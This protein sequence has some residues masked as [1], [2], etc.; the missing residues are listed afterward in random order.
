LFKQQS[1]TQSDED[2]FISR[3]YIGDYYDYRY[4]APEDLAGPHLIWIKTSLENI[5]GKI[6]AYGKKCEFKPGERLYLKRTLFTPGIGKGYWVFYIENDSGISYE[7]TEFQNDH[8]TST[9]KIFQS[10]FQQ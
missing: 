5:F 6:S 8:K 3:R 9:E 10:D 4:T 2:F 7:A 1:S